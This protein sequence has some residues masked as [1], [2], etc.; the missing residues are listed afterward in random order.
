MQRIRLALALVALA[1]P[2]LAQVSPDPLPGATT[3]GAFTAMDSAARLQALT[4]TQ[5]LGDDL[6]GADPA[7]AGQWADEVAAACA[8]HPERPLADAAAQALGAD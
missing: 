1:A 4:A 8:G 5:P 2:A 7:L 3:C 6:G